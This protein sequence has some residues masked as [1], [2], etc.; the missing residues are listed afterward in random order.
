MKY[1]S[2]AN[3]NNDER[4]M[5]INNIIQRRGQCHRDLYKPFLLKYLNQT[6]RE[7]VWK[8]TLFLNHADPLN[9]LDNRADV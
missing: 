7:L 2:I 9:K 5:I 1:K 4:I 8:G 6:M 3:G